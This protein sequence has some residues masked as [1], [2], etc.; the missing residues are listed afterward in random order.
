MSIRTHAAIQSA[1]LSVV[2]CFGPASAPAQT[3]G[4]MATIRVDASEAP[5]GIMSAHLRLPVNAGPL[6]LV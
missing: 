5:R 2:V 4:G 6:T 1:L 3:S